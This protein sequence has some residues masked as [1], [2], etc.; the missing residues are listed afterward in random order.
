MYMYVRVVKKTLLI[1][2]QQSMKVACCKMSFVTD[3][4]CQP[5]RVTRA[6]MHPDW[7]L[8]HW[9]VNLLEVRVDAVEYA[10]I[11]V[12]VHVTY[13]YVCM[14]LE[15]REQRLINHGR[16]KWVEWGL[17]RRHLSHSWSLEKKI[18]SFLWSHIRCIFCDINIENW[19][20]HVSISLTLHV[21]NSIIHLCI[22][23]KCQVAA[24]S[25]TAGSGVCQKHV[26]TPKYEARDAEPGSAVYS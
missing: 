21:E 4:V 2:K 13:V 8:L 20:I 6:S 7:P 15:V 3:V 25:L 9:T 23:N 22:F 12:H 10:Y 18:T 5:L 11:C 1:H 26:S 16:S 24:V 14:W 19:S 17:Q